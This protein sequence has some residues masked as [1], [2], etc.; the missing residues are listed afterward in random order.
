[1]HH[2][3]ANVKTM[4]ATRNY[5]LT[6]RQLLDICTAHAPVALKLYEEEYWGDS[7]SLKRK[8][9]V[10]GEETK[11]NFHGQDL[12][13]TFSTLRII[14]P[15]SFYIDVA[16]FGSELY[17]IVLTVP[18]TEDE[19]VTGG[20]TLVTDELN[21]AKSKIAEHQQNFLQGNYTSLAHIGYPE[22]QQLVDCDNLCELVYAF[23]SS[24]N[25]ECTLKTAYTEA[26]VKAYRQKWSAAAGLLKNSQ[27]FFPLFY[28]V[29]LENMNE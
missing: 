19:L 24:H 23:P 7:L 16:K 29:A 21:P 26:E 5:V 20:L 18:D 11:E 2:F 8:D 4:E 3:T 25:M 9:C 28:D 10:S 14:F 12:V 13:A 22:T 17:Y 1:M 15:R 27:G 6:F